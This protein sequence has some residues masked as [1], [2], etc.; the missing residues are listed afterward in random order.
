M[1]ERGSCG[2]VDLPRPRRAGCQVAARTYRSWK[3]PGRPVAARTV[4]DAVIIDALLAT[5]RHPR[6]ALRAPEDDPPPA[7]AGTAGG[8]LHRG[9]A[10]GRPGHERGAPR[11]GRPDHG[12]GARTAAA[13][14]T[15]WTA[16]SPPPHPTPVGSR[17]SPTCGTWAGFVYV[18]FVVDV[19]AQ[20]I[21]GW[22]AATN[23]RTDLV[24]TPLRI[25]LW[26]RGRQGT[27][28]R[29]RPAAPPL[30]RRQSS[31]PRSGS[32]STSPSRASRP[33]SG[34]SATPTTTP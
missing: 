27:P 12:P 18:A 8:V 4:S 34:P 22:H 19:F 7:P 1:R 9:P 25:A 33:R 2:R 24:L 11:Q 6:T 32:P 21:V 17:T 14:V 15:C 3:Q 28:G 10:D 31:T 23:K 5:R 13:P 30:R 29:A 16:T 26:D 20:R